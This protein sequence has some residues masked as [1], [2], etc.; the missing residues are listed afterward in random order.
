[1]TAEAWPRLPLA[2][3]ADTYAT[4]HLW[5]QILGKTRLALSPPQNHW[6]HVAL[7]VTPCGLG[8]SAIPDGDRTFEIELDLVAHQLVL[9]TCDGATHSRPLVAEP[10]A[11]FYAAYLELLRSVGI[12][13]R[14]WPV[15]AEVADTTRFTDDRKHGSYDPDAA[16]RF[17][18]LLRHADRVLKA[19]RGDFLGKQSPVHFWWGAFDLAM[20]TF[21]GRR[22]PSVPSG[23]PYIADRIV[24]EA[25]SHEVTSVG[26]WP[27]G[28]FGVVREP[29]VTEPAFYAYA[30]PE[31]PG[32]KELKV[33]SPG[34]YYHPTMGEWIL[35]HEAV[36]AHADREASIRWF[37]EDTYRGAAELGGWDR[38]ALERRS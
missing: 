31:P 16:T 1:M 27:G 24:K 8:T 12:Q 13:V 18:T 9:R 17:H 6:W 3:W 2:E 36:R 26:W 11:D 4:L 14:I 20:T 34:A 7:Y 22:V 15:P 10:V 25:Y 30:V 5:T 19:C 28:G 33:R 37:V 29:V 23:I 32:F 21:S 38:A 35:P